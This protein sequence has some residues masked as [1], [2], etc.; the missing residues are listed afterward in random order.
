MAVTLAS[1]QSNSYKIEGSTEG[2]EDGDTILLTTDMENG[3]PSD[4]II[5]K[6]GRFSCSG[7][8]DSLFFCI[9]YSPSGQFE[10]LPM[11]V[12]SGIIHVHLSKQP[13]ASKV[14]GTKINDDF[15]ALNDSAMAMSKKFI[16]I[17]QQYGNDVTDAQR[18]EIERQVLQ[19]QLSLTNCLYK[20]AERNMDNELGYMIVTSGADFDDEQLLK[21]INMMPKRFRSR[22]L[23]KDLEYEIKNIPDDEAYPDDFFPDDSVSGYY[24]NDLLE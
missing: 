23:I 6:D 13:G 20:T 12:E 4:T 10:A 14:S 22:E 21:L 19:A 18:A 24:A 17:A 9:L 11:F 5:I 7:E 3:I 15:Q 8:T 16:E 1:C 2:F